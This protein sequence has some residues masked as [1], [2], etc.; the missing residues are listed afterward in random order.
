MYRPEKLLKPTDIPK[1][2]IDE[3]KSDKKTE[4]PEQQ[5]ET[6]KVEEK[7]EVKVEIK[8]DQQHHPNVQ[9]PVSPSKTLKSKKG[10]KQHTQLVQKKSKFMIPPEVARTL[11]A[12]EREKK[13]KEIVVEAFVTAAWR[14]ERAESNKWLRWKYAG[15]EK[16]KN[17]WLESNGVEDMGWAVGRRIYEKEEIEV[18]TIFTKIAKMRF[19]KCEFL[20][21][22]FYPKKIPLHKIHI[23]I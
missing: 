15:T 20:R 11:T 17:D 14:N 10:K 3:K 23:S 8:T 21:Y 7:V 6:S 4:K 19:C 2:V 18:S 22:T 9:V 16:K 13:L 5:T 12:K 1:H